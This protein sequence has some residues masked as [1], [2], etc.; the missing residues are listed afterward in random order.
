MAPE[1]ALDAPMPVAAGKLTETA[2]DRVDVVELT[3]TK[4]LAL[5]P[6]VSVSSVH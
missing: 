4:F 3:G 2:G 6:V 1:P 5:V